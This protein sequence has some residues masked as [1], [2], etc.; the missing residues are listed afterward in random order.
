MHG[1][2]LHHESDDVVGNFERMKFKECKTE[3]TI[4]SSPAPTQK[5]ARRSLRQLCCAPL[6]RKTVR[7]WE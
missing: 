2:H 1:L 6:Q 5:S 4:I 7:R 3:E